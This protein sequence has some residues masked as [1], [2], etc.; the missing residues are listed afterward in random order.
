MTNDPIQLWLNAAGRFPLLPAVEM[1]RLAKKRD[2]FEP[3]SP[4]YVKI[5]NKICEHNLRLVPN[6]V[7][8]YLSKRN[9][10]SMRSEVT[11]DLL[12]QGYLG[13]RRAAEKFDARRGFAFSTYAYSWIY[14]SVTRWHNSQDRAIYIPENSVCEFL[15]RQRHGHPSKAKNG[16]I[17]A[18]IMAATARSLDVSSIDKKAGDYD[19]EGMTIADVISEDN[20]ILSRHSAPEGRA[21][22]ELKDLMAECGIEPR[23]QDIVLAYAKRG[24]M[25]VV[26]SRLSLSSKRC[27][28][29]YQEAVR[30]MKAKAL[31]KEEEKAARLAVKLKSNNTTST[32]N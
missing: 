6:I 9:G 8:K 14:Q 11:S 29:L 25:S 12:Q 13:L 5:V 16:K 19:D 31:E 26:A 24:R 23:T 10:L 2:T 21:E 4:A 7:R 3:G 32:R 20:R 22:L 28:G 1:L 30:T 27:Q 18:D 17:P 15:Y